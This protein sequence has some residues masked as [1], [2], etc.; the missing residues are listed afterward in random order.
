MKK[1]SQ[2]LTSGFIL[3]ECIVALAILTTTVFL[4]QTSQVHALKET[5]K[6]QEELQMLRVLYEETKERR[7]YQMKTANYQVTRNGS[8]TIS[9]QTS[10]MAQ[11]KISTKQQDW[12]IIRE[13]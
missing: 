1:R 6:S 2:P 3:L 4:F 12:A 9:Y 8:F 11:A 10:P 7:Q 13:K 5:K